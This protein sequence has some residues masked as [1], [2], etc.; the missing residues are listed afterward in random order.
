MCGKQVTHQGSSY[1]PQCNGL[2]TPRGRE[3]SFP[4]HS[5]HLHPDGFF[6]EDEKIISP[7][8]LAKS[9]I[10]YTTLPSPGKMGEKQFLG[11]PVASHR[12]PGVHIDVSWVQRP[13]KH[14][15]NWTFLRGPYVMGSGKYQHQPGFMGLSEKF[16]SHSTYK[17]SF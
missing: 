9:R 2:Q 8:H 10:C 16:R 15:V 1:R 7:L 17:K 5:L 6:V 12:C 3:Y 13:I 14:G 4:H 11:S